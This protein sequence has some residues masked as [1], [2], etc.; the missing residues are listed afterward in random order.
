[1]QLSKDAL[2]SNNEVSNSD[3]C[4]VNWDP[5]N[6]LLYYWN[7]DA[8]VPCPKFNSVFGFLSSKSLVKL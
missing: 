8:T 2:F 6:L 7:I 1:M 4:T 5:P 3:V